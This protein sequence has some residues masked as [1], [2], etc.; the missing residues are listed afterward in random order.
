MD[1]DVREWFRRRT[2]R[3]SQFDSA[4]LLA[5]KHRAGA[6]ISVV[7]PAL[8]EERTVGEIVERIRDCLIEDVQLVDELVV[9][10]S[11]SQDRTADVAH[12]AGASVVSAEELL[13][14]HGR[15]PGKGD[16]LWKSLFATTGD[17]VAFLD[18][19]LIDFD[20]SFVTGLV[21]PLLTDPQVGYVKGLYDRPLQTSEGIAPEGG[22][23][24]TELLARPLLNAIWPELAGFVQPLSGEYAGRRSL[25]EAVPFASGYGVEIALL[26]DLLQLAGLNALAQTDLGVR[27]HSHQADPALGRMAGQILQTALHRAPWAPWATAESSMLTQFVRVEDGHEFVD[28]D[29]AT[30][31][32]PPMR[33]LPEYTRL[34]ATSGSPPALPGSRGN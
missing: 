28:W 9:I 27:R 23:R 4:S 12:A 20:P 5:A 32:R 11:G 30:L 18:A 6:R 33:T 29:V 26:I 16:A 31:D 14:S 21:G 2:Y 1:N 15:R 8:N 34:R 7:L 25:L 10:D 19:D 3:T 13:H 24:V 17:I 22:G